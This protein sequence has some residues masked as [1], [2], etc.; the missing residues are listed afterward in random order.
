M[1]LNHFADRDSQIQQVTQQIEGVEDDRNER[2]KVMRVP[3]NST[4]AAE[5]W[6]ERPQA[7]PPSRTIPSR[8]FEDVLPYPSI[9]STPYARLNDC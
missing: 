9:V 1:L 4:A 5:R 3:V 2:K 7:G 6:A 8:R